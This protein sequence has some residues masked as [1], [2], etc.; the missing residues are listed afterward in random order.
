M[1]TKQ[2]RLGGYY[3]L[4][5]NVLGSISAAI[6]SSPENSYTSPSIFM[7]FWVSIKLN[8]PPGTSFVAPTSWFD[9]DSFSSCVC[10]VFFVLFLV[11]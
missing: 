5:F 11:Y 2:N 9:R 6:K 7:S 3:R 10:S 4:N 8:K 1:Q